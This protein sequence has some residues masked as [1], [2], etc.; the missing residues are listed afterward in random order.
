MPMATSARAKTTP[1]TTRPTLSKRPSDDFLAGLATGE[2]PDCTAPAN[3][4]SLFMLS[5][6]LTITIIDYSIVR[7]IANI[8]LGVFWQETTICHVVR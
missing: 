2:P 5:P 8:K 3:D 7:L 6:L 1:M 4:T